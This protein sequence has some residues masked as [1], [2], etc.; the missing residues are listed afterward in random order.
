MYVTLGFYIW[1]KNL[2]F[3]HTDNV[4]LEK[5]LNFLQLS[6]FDCEMEVI[7]VFLHSVDK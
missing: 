6:F 2:A 1:I 7:L 4:T 5:L 3:V